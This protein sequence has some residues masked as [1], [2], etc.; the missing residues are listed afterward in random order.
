MKLFPEGLKSLV[1]NFK[2]AETIAYVRTRKYLM[3]P[4]FEKEIIYFIGKRFINLPASIKKLDTR[5]WLVLMN[6]L[7]L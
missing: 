2:S 7:Y 3:I 4:V 6:L 5:G 1:N